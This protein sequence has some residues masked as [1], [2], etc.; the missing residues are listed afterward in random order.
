VR[1]APLGGGRL[2]LRGVDI[3]RRCVSTRLYF[4]LFP[5][6][7]RPVFSLFPPVLAPAAFL[8][9]SQSLAL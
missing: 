1:P 2:F 4:R 5:L 7:L 6:N 3:T 9:P 8:S